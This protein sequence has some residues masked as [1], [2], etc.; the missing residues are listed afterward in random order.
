MT[1]TYP[2]LDRARKILWLVTGASKLEMLGRLQRADA[3]IPGGR[4]RPDRAL[5]LAD[6]DATGGPRP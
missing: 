2:L 1:V 4:V 3:S 6:R 5:V